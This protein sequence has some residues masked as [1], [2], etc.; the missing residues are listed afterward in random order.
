MKPNN[1]QPKDWKEGRRKRALKLKYLGWKQVEIAEALGVSKA[2]VSQ[3]VFAAQLKG[4]EA[5]RAK[6]RPNGPVKLTAQQLELIPDLLSHGAEAYGFLGD[7]WTCARVAEVIRQEFG[8]SYHKAHVSR[9]LKALDWTPQLPLER[10]WQRDEQAI[11]QWRT[12]RW[13]K[14]K[15]RRL[16]RGSP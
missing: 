7:V 15:K 8:V 10:A 5:W 12:E 13:P 16:R 4:P 3:W 1:L 9:L 14:L 2:A 11:E 6:P